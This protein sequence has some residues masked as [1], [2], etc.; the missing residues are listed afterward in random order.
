MGDSE[1]VVK[2]Y[3]S[4]ETT[5]E[6]VLIRVCHYLKAF[7]IYHLHLVSKSMKV[8]IL[9][10]RAVKALLWMDEK[11]VKGLPTFGLQLQ[12]LETFCLSMQGAGERVWNIKGTDILKLPK[13]LTN[14]RLGF[15][16]AH[17]L[18][19]SHY[20]PKFFKGQHRSNIYGT[21]SDFAHLYDLKA[22]FPQL[23]KL[24]LAGE[25]AELGTRLLSFFSPTLTSASV[26]SVTYKTYAYDGPLPPNL[27]EL[28]L[29]GVQKINWDHVAPLTQLERLETPTLNEPVPSQFSP[30]LQ[31]LLLGW[32]DMA[33]PSSSLHSL[34]QLDNLHT[35]SCGSPSIIPYLPR[36]LTE[37]R[38]T[39]GTAVP[40][41]DLHNLPRQLKI[42][43][44]FRL[45][46]NLS[47]FKFWPPSLTQL[48]FSLPA[49]DTFGPEDPRWLCLPKGLTQ[50]RAD[51]PEYNPLEIHP[52]MIPPLLKRMNMRKYGLENEIINLS[53]LEHM[54][55]LSVLLFPLDNRRRSSASSK[56]EKK[57]PL[58]LELS[59]LSI[60]PSCSFHFVLPSKLTTLTWNCHH[61]ENR[62]ALMPDTWCFRDS[63][64]SWLPDS[65]T[66]FECDDARLLTEKF[67]AN[68][69]RGLLTLSIDMHYKNSPVLFSSEALKALPPRLTHLCT[70]MDA[71]A[72]DSFVPFLPRSLTCLEISRMTTFNDSSVQ[73][74][75]RG[76][77]FLHMRQQIHG[78][79]DAC[80]ESLPRGLEQLQLEHNK[81]LTPE[82]FFGRG[83][84][85]LNYLDIRG[86]QNFTKKRVMKC[87]PPYIQ[88]KGRKFSKD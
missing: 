31:H 49:H 74:L 66:S 45:T 11:F 84:P 68:L 77:L 44:C 85:N 78:I 22:A 86:N 6:D 42:F 5:L 10:R 65:L 4:L 40:A 63:F 55:Y 28:K 34:S 87:A 38:I 32:S 13:S 37:V 54:H 52:S 64:A 36:T 39:G 17:S 30:S 69:P 41:E 56:S 67:F 24:E 53:H 47:N 1:S 71:N 81:E 23:Q 62:I 73:H 26:S 60:D 14:L 59:G 2:A 25:N 43:S 75:P 8:R 79:T 48:E 19:F 72:D 35:I 29:T 50:L 80:I 33:W 46:G 27:R 61:Y 58:D 18:W 70:V 76:L 12:H 21:E 83:F 16:G 82:A 88:I 7:D 51:S 15:S 9:T 57:A 20:S 3:C